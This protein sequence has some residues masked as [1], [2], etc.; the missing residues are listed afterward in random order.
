[1]ENS[2][3]FGGRGGGSLLFLFSFHSLSNSIQRSWY[4]LIFSSYLVFNWHTNINRTH[5]SS[6]LVYNY[7]PHRNV[8]VSKIKVPLCFNVVTLGECCH[9]LQW[10]SML[11]LPH[12]HQWIC[13]A[14]L[15]YLI[16]MMY[17]P[18]GYSLRSNALQFQVDP[19]LRIYINIKRNCL[20]S[21]R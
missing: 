21:I 3:S 9:Q 1:M 17:L 2:Y 6:F 16:C 20:E 12:K 10:R 4:F 11:C 13:L 14:T 8:M 15:S 18:V 7:S 19:S 5:A